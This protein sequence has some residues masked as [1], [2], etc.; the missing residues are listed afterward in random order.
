MS[1]WGEAL[2]CGGSE[3]GGGERGEELTLDWLPNLNPWYGAGA[4][5]IDGRDGEEWGRWSHAR[6]LPLPSMSLVWIFY[7]TD[8][9]RMRSEMHWLPNPPRIGLQLQEAEEDGN[10]HSSAEPTRASLL[11][12]R[13]VVAREGLLFTVCS[14]RILSTYIVEVGSKGVNAN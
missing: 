14:A 10:C 4:V 13:A 5:C 9:S 7:N 8:P 6:L 11:W 12:H 3:A 2:H 1:P